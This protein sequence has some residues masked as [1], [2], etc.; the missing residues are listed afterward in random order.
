MLQN[1]LQLQYNKENLVVEAVNDD[2]HRYAR[3]QNKSQSSEVVQIVN[4]EYKSY[5]ITILKEKQLPQIGYRAFF[6][7]KIKHFIRI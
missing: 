1:Q 5:K 4:P 6:Y 3:I 2:N 7:S